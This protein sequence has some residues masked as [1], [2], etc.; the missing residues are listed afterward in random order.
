M[1]HPGTATEEDLEAIRMGGADFDGDGDTAEGIAGE[2][3]TLG[4]FL[5]AAL[6]SYA[7]DVVGTGIV[8]DSHSYPY[9][10]TDTGE[11]YGTWTPSLLRGAYNYQYLMK[12]PGAYAHNPKY[13]IQILYDSL[14]GLGADVSG[15]VRP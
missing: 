10:F 12:D 13:I 9:W 2:V 6:E 15:M 3:E 4:E 14:A 1:C 5:Y 8:Y 7:T 11:S